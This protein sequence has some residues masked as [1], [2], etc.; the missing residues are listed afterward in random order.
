MR[1]TIVDDFMSNKQTEYLLNFYK[2]NVH[3]RKKW[4]TTFPISI[5]GL[6]KDLENKYNRF[7][8]KNCVDWIEIVHWPEGSFQE[9]HLDSSSQSTVFT[10][11]TY[12]NDDFVGR[13]TAFEDGTTVKPKKG[14]TLF[15][16]G[17]VLS[18]KVNLIKKGN[19]YTVAVW[20]QRRYVHANL[21]KIAKRWEDPVKIN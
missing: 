8:K 18:H 12:L 5:T 20:Y 10:S 7:D 2:N 13:E 9:L 16:D 4:R 11:I 6:F 17:A 21:Q 14:R 1:I 19:R 15:F 3:L